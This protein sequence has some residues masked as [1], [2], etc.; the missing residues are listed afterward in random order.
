VDEGTP[1]GGSISPLLAN[2]FDLWIQWWRRKRARGDVIVV[3]FADD[4]VLGFQ[5]RSEAVRFL[6]ELRD[7]FRKFGLEL[8]PD[9]TRLIAFGR[10]AAVCLY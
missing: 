4:I 2:A 7:R 9:K 5:H 8:H 6:A 3:R 1:Q 10:Y